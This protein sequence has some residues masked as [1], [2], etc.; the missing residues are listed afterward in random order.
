MNP[1]TVSLIALAGMAA[2]YGLGWYAGRDW[3]RRQIAKLARSYVKQWYPHG[4]P[5]EA[6]TDMD[7]MAQVLDGLAN[8]IDRGMKRTEN[9]HG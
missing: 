4:V 1:D 6:E 3:A 8:S 9:K 7:V 5:D 2:C